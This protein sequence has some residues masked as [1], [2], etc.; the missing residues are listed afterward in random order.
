MYQKDF[1]T[2]H[3]TMI[4]QLLDFTFMT[5]YWNLQEDP[6]SS[7]IETIEINSTPILTH[8]I[9]ETLQKKL[10]PRIYLSHDIET[11]FR[12]LLVAI[13]EHPFYGG[14]LETTCFTDLELGFR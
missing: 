1:E 2:L 8:E 10:I 14:G 3:Q 9:L 12:H 11:Y 5:G 6:I 13:R 7:N 4:P